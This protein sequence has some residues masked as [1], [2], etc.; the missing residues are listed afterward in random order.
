MP[1]VAEEIWERIGGKGFVIDAEFP[2]GDSG[3]VDYPLEMGEELVSLVRHDA[4]RIIE[5]LGLKAGK[6]TL[7]V[8]AEWKFRA[9]G[10]LRERK[11]L[12]ALME[13]AK[14]EGLDMGAV[15]K[16]G[17]ALM[18]KVHSLP[19]VLG[20]SEEY[21]SLSDSAGFLA[22]ELGAEVEVRKEEEGGHP[23]A[24]QA[25]PGKPAIIIE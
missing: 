13:W 23:K 10:L 4:E 12:K 9:Y 1:H 22:K 14:G 20:P 17:K 21:E 24:S 11:D 2:E 19:E 3:L 7:Y 16:F 5:R 8:P 25:L 18:G 6:V 15:S